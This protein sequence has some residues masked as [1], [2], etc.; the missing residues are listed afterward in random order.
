MVQRYHLIIELK[1]GS[2]REFFS[3]GA[4]RY[5]KSNEND[6]SAQIKRAQDRYIA[7]ILIWYYVLRAT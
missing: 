1:D 2:V 3:D 7:E 5:V 6:L 4:E